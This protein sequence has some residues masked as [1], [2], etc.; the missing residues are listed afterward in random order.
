[1]RGHLFVS[2]VHLTACSALPAELRDVVIGLI[3]NSNVHGR[4]GSALLRGHCNHIIVLLVVASNQLLPLSGNP[5]RVATTL[6]SL[7]L[8]LA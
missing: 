5:A 8:D 6:V 7:R 4:L 1:M 2:R 3:T